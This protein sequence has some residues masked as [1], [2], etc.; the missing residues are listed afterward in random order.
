MRGEAAK[1]RAIIWLHLHVSVF[2]ALLLIFL[3]KWR[4]AGEQGHWENVL[5]NRNFSALLISAAWR[6]PVLGESTHRPWQRGGGGGGRRRRRAASF[7]FLIT[8]L[9]RSYWALRVLS[10]SEIMN[11][12]L[13][14][15]EWLW[16]IKVCKSIM[17]S[18]LRLYTCWKQKRTYIIQ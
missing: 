15:A 6:P 4:T 8:N 9:K 5:V 3:W 2:P 13:L 18:N 12:L 1:H 10:P 11:A 7:Y 17:W 14:K 16:R